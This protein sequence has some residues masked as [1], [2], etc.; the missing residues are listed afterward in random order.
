MGLTVRMCGRDWAGGSHGPLESI[1]MVQKSQTCCLLVNSAL[2]HLNG[3]AEEH[4]ASV[5]SGT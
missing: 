5:R 3:E 2:N 1:P 4:R